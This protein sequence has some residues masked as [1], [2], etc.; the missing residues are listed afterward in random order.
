MPPNPIFAVFAGALGIG[1]FFMILWE[2]FETIVL[3]RTVTRGVRLTRLFYVG[4]W[5]VTWRTA[6]RHNP[7]GKRELFLSFF[8][9]LSLPL[10]F[11]IWAAMLVFSFALME[12][13]LGP[14]AYSPARAQTDF[15]TDLYQSGVT[16]FTL[17]YGDITPLTSPARALSVTEAGV[18]FGFLALVISYLPVL[19][20]AFSRREAAISRRDGRAGS[21]PTAGELLRRH[22]QAQ[23]MEA[24]IS[25]LSEWEAWSSELLESHL[26]YPVLPYYRSQ[27]DHQSW[28]SALT[29]IMDTCA[30]LIIGVQGGPPWQAALQWQARMTFA[31]ARH[32]IID[33]AYVFHT[34]PK[35]LEPERLTPR[36]LARL[37][38]ELAAMGL[39]LCDGPEDT[40][41]L[42]ELRGLYE[43]YVHSLSEF[44]LFALPP[45]QGDPL[46]QDN[47]QTSAWDSML[48][49]TDEHLHFR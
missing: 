12:W 21:P 26:S 17:G 22:A 45:W 32:T 28:L 41:N 2:A 10:L 44:F 13:A 48:N 35:S 24:L 37:R 9:P 34:A 49:T 6:R 20:Q 40:Q 4:F 39:P 19:Y 1:L 33:L 38:A 3:P 42:E 30:V 8:G 7:S 36:G 23:N 11:G 16:F 47:W 29:A 14:Y 46:S 25:L 31:M 18:G 15:G 27:H 5:R 43:P